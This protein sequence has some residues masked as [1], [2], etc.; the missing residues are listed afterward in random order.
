[1]NVMKVRILIA[2]VLLALYPFRSDA[3]DMVKAVT[4]LLNE[5]SYSYILE[6]TFPLSKALNS[7]A[8]RPRNLMFGAFFKF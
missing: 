6:S 2:G 1:M 4:N 8:I 5:T 3:Q 7:Y